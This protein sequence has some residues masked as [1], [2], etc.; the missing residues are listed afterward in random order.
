MWGPSRSPPR[1]R[2]G[3]TEFRVQRV[4]H[5]RPILLGDLDHH[6]AT[7]P[8]WLFR[9]HQRGAGVLQARFREQNHVTNNQASDIR[10]Q[11]FGLKIV[12][13]SVRRRPRVSDRWW[14]SSPAPA[15]LGQRDDA[16]VAALGETADLHE[17]IGP[18]RIKARVTELAS[19]PEDDLVAFLE[20]DAIGDDAIALRRVAAERDL[21]GRGADMVGGLGSGHLERVVELCRDR[22]T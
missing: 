14:I 1:G 22:S 19:L 20:A 21:F 5:D 17:E 13:V 7:A 9:R 12:R 3:D 6:H 16:A 15:P 10:A 2:G 11:R 18:A 8:L 4:S